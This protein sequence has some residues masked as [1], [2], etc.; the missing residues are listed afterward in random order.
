MRLYSPR[1][2][3]TCRPGL[4]PGLRFPN[5]YAFEISSVTQVVVSSFQLPVC[6][7]QMHPMHPA[8]ADHE[9]IALWLEVALLVM[10]FQIT[11]LREDNIVKVQKVNVNGEIQSFDSN[12]LVCGTLHHI[13]SVEFQIPPS[14]KRP[15]KK[16]NQSGHRCIYHRCDWSSSLLIPSQQG[17]VGENLQPPIVCSAMSHPTCIRLWYWC[18][19]IGSNIYGREANGWDLTLA[20]RIQLFAW[21]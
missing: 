12:R 20:S 7:L 15:C 2:L 21:P 6:R 13:L 10:S 8:S 1:L 4:E 19:Q 14:P 9:L 18:H 5:H 17:F 16:T 11:L 3:S